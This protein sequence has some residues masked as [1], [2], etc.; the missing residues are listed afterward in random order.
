MHGAY[1]HEISQPFAFQI[2]HRLAQQISH[3]M[4]ANIHFGSSDLRE[5]DMNYL[6]FARNNVVISHVLNYCSDWQLA[7]MC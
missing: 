6:K 5:F 1:L 4:P 2:S 3:R 7:A